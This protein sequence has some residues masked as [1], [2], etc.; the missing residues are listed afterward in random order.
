[1]TMTPRR[2][3]AAGGVAALATLY[4]MN[5]SWLAPEPAGPTRWLAHRGVHQT[6]SLEGVDNDTCTA[7]RIRPPTHGLIE[8]TIPSMRAAFEAGAS[9]VELDVHVSN[10]RQLV[11]FH[12]HTLDCRTDGH[13]TIED[14]DLAELRPLDLGYGYTADG[15][16]TWP[17]RG[18]GVGLL[19]TLPEVLAAFPTESFLIHFK[20]NTPGDG[21][22]LADLLAATPD[23][24]RDRFIV[25]GG[26]RP[27]EAATTRLPWLASLDKS[28]TKGCLGAYLAYGWLGVTPS[29]CDDRWLALPISHA[30][31]MWGWPN[32]FQAR[33]DAAGATVLLLGP[34]DGGPAA[35]VDDEAT[36]SLVPPDFGGYV[37]TNRIE[38]VGE[39]STR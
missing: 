14:H 19:V 37:W 18:T 36:R 38:T 10:D 30:R 34:Y 13:G 27:V 2:V 6:F 11:V 16:T 9:V 4:L 3:G 5:A 28:A 17:L 31:W 12:D 7:S 15:G 33:M 39:T 20:S 21:D 25:Y 32:R 22:L 8:N 29:A 26:Q 23:T 24:E 1:M 35:G